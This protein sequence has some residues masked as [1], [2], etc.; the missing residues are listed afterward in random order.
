MIH[1]PEDMTVTVAADVTL[2]ELQ[3]ELAKSRQWLPLDP[4]N[5]ALTLREILDRNESGPRRY[6]YGTARDY[7]IGLS[8]TLAD[9]R[10]VK[11]GGQVVKNVAGYDLQK[12]F[13]GSGGTLGTIWEITFKLRPQ[14]EAEAFMAQECGPAEL[15]HFAKCGRAEKMIEQVV[16]SDLQPVALDFVGHNDGRYE[17]VLG[18]DGPRTEV[19]WQLVL[20][21]RLGFTTPTTL[22]YDRSFRAGT[23]TLR[24][25]SVLPSRLLDSIRALEH[26]PFVARAGNG[27]VF[28]RAATGRV[29]RHTQTATQLLERRLKDAFD[30]KHL[31]PDLPA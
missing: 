16:A 22:E 12:L 31:L 23:N 15:P 28:H 26:P 18:F 25:L 30:P 10:V 27:V 6:G 17:V 29:S 5:P 1:T 7:V 13:L 24:K 3:T 2:A 8:V 4:P 14:P 19:D 20:A 21:A 9:G 11:S